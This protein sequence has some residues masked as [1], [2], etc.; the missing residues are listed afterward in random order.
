VPDLTRH[1]T[2]IHMPRARASALLGRA[3]AAGRGREED[4]RWRKK[5]RK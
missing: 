4:Q 5:I 1:A 2:V 3:E